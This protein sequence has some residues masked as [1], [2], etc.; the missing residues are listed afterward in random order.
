MSAQ[1]PNAGREFKDPGEAEPCGEALQHRR[2]L[3]EATDRWHEVMRK[4]GIKPRVVESPP[5]QS[6]AKRIRPAIVPMG[7]SSLGSV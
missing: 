4:E 1:Q 6:L 3:R 7:G 5:T 2:A